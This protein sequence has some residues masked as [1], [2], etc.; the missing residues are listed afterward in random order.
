MFTLPWLVSTIIAVIAL[1]VSLR[2]YRRRYAEDVRSSV[3]PSARPYKIAWT[4]KSRSDPTQTLYLVTEWECVLINVGERAVNITEWHVMDPMS[5]GVVRFPHIYK[6]KNGRQ[7][8]G[9]QKLFEPDIDADSGA[10]DEEMPWPM[11]LPPGISK[12]FKL[13]LGLPIDRAC[14]DLI[15]AELNSGRMADDVQEIFRFLR[16]KG[17]TIYGSRTIDL[18][19]PIYFQSATGKRFIDM[20]FLNRAPG[21]TRV[22]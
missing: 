19:V 4:W 16:G 6:I 21:L 7:E 12:T 11:D 20:A 1:I 15:Q 8:H 5:S 3:L 18:L 9:P 13:K 17:L 2:T 22:S 10:P 14:Q